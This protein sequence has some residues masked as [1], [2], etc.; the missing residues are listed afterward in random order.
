MKT[1]YIQACNTLHIH[2]YTI[3][4]KENKLSIMLV[5]VYKKFGETDCPKAQNKMSATNRA[6]NIMIIC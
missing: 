2:R 6:L 5:I 4:K 3:Y 1:I